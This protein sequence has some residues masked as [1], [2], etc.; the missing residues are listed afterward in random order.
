MRKL[1][2]FAATGITALGLALATPAESRADDDHRHRRR[3][4]SFS[5]GISTPGFHFDIDRGYRGYGLY[6]APIHR[7]FYGPAYGYVPAPT[8]VVPTEMHWTPWRG[9]HQHGYIHVPHRGH[10]HT[11]PY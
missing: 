5:F 1:M 4:G 2:C 10:Y 6:R 11:Y 9:W 8:I 7:G 3:G